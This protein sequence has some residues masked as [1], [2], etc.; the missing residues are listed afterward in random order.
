MSN[1]TAPRTGNH[2]S[3]LNSVYYATQTR[4]VESWMGKTKINME[5]A[6]RSDV[7]AHG[8]GR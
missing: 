7:D 1:G 4:S 5:G 6:N 3:T 2:V 8:S